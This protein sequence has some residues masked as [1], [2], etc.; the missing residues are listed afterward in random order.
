MSG[1]F[2]QLV[3]Q[4]S[5]LRAEWREKMTGESLRFILKRETLLS[6]PSGAVNVLCHQWEGAEQRM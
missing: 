6:F 4:L 5:H 3:P 2:L 1:A